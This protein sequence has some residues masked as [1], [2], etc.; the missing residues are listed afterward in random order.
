MS[1]GGLAHINL[2]FSFSYFKQVNDNGI[3]L[4]ENPYSWNLVANVLFLE[5]PAGVGYSYADDKNYTTDDDQVG[6]RS[7]VIGQ[8]TKKPKNK[9][10]IWYLMFYF[11]KHQL[12]WVIP[13]QM[14]KTTPMMTR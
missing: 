12:G 14:M 11:K 1:E 2:H 8:Y 5:A 10:G 7:S 6:Q 9:A 3:T 13:M 4:Y